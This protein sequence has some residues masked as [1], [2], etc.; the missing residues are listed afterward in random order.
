MWVPSAFTRTCGFLRRL[1][2]RMFSVKPSVNQRHQAF[3]LLRIVARLAFYAPSGILGMPPIRLPV[4]FAVD[5]RRI[6]TA[7]LAP[8][9]KR[10]ELGQTLTGCEEPSMGA[11]AK[12]NFLTAAAVA[13]SS[14]NAVS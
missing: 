12:R 2:K 3:S 13:G 9:T 10:Q 4:T 6:K 7:I 14:R 8:R 11:G 5:I 1:P